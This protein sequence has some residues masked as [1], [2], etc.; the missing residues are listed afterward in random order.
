MQ[1]ITGGIDLT[2]EP[3]TDMRKGGY[4][5]YVFA[6]NHAHPLWSGISREHLQMFNGGYGGEGV[7]EHHVSAN[8]PVTIHARCGM[9]L[10]HAAVFELRSGRGRVLVSRLQLRGRLA[11]S[12]GN[13]SLYSR[14]PDPVL[15]QYLLNLLS[16][17]A[18]D[19]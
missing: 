5:S 12:A 15:Q 1:Q 8:L 14:R 16:Y 18:Q 17:A 7:S 9:Q 11:E 13:E 10:K 19:D 6:E 3:R 4:D 2:I